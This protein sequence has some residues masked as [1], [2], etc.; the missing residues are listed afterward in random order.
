MVT[1]AHSAESAAEILDAVIPHKRANSAA[2]RAAERMLYRGTADACCAFSK[3]EQPRNGNRDASSGGLF[4]LRLGRILW[5][6][7]SLRFRRLGNPGRW[8]AGGKRFF[9]GFFDRIWILRERRGI[10]LVAVI[11]S[12]WRRFLFFS[13]LGHKK[14]ILPSLANAKS[15]SEMPMP[16]RYAANRD[17]V[18]V[19][20]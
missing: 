12:R 17:A 6:W 3:T 16:A 19:V 18:A 8:I 20:N 10:L 11:G 7:F 5:L 4:A 15:Y 14:L 2:I 13:G 1:P 9:G